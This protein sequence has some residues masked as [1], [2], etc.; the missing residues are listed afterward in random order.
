[1]PIRPEAIALAGVVDQGCECVP[2]CGYQ[3]SQAVVAPC[4]SMEHHDCL[5]HWVMSSSAACPWSSAAARLYR[6]WM[7][8]Y[9]EYVEPT[10]PWDRR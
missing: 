3:C 10:M 4:C 7:S 6:P 9:D 2:S 5:P 8:E 1:M